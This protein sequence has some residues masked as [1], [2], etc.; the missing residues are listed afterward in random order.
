[1]VAVRPFCA[2]RYN[3]ERVSDLSAVIAPPYDAIDPDEQDELYAA[4]P[5]N[6]VRL[7]L[8]RQG[9]DDTPEDNRYTRA[10]RDFHAWCDRQ[11]LRADPQPAFYLVEHAFE[12][13]G[14]ACA[15][16]GFLALLELTD[17]M[18]RAIYRHEETLAAPKADRT[19]LLEAL[20][21][22]LCPIF[23]VY[24]D[25]GGA[26]QAILQGVARRAPP[27]VQASFRGEPIRAW[28]VTGSDLIQEVTSRLASVA[29]LIAD[30]HHRFEVA[31]ANR[32][33]Y[34]TLMAYFVSME[35]PAL[36]V[37]PIHRVV[38]QDGHP[39]PRALGRVERADDLAS[40]MRWLNE[41][42]EAGRFG[43]YDGQALYRLTLDP[44]RL[45]RWL[46]APPVP[47]PL[48]ALDVSLLHELILPSLQ[49]MGA[50]VQYT[51]DAPHALEAVDRGQ[52]SSAWLLR[53]IP[54]QHV[55]ALA[56]QG[57]TLPPKSTYFYPK[58]PSGLTIH[59]L[60]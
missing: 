34:G 12:H 16:L 26:I 29:V 24:P 4:S 38:Q 11:I 52:G 46:R 33:R 36:M 56:S 19:R 1:M 37:R 7:I 60:A 35:D 13:E 55:Y 43:W 9:P 32:S 21:A 27:T 41:G 50:G 51:A 59:R 42:C 28:V 22:N 54:L 40:V 5:Y 3:P 17:A 49:L 30:G 53:G 57:F 48:A 20:P 39:D 6:I 47:P 23:C 45:A 10:E 15:R 31:Y 44:E 25:A 14:C 58:V 18:E 8:G 2:L